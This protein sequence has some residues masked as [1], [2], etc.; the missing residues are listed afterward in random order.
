MR[1]FVLLFPK[2][3]LALVVAVVVLIIAVWAFSG[4]E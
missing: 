1:E 4:R 2:V 3:V